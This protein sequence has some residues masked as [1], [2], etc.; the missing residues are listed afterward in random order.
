MIH[1]AIIFLCDTS[2]LLQIAESAKVNHLKPYAYFKQLLTELP[3][4]IDEDGNIDPSTL[5]DL[6]S[7]SK[8]LSEECYKGR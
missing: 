2:C 4:R 6:M 5:D 1:G 8:D 3:Y 7:W